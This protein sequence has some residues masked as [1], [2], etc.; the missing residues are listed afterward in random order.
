VNFRGEQT[1]RKTEAE[2]Y[3]GESVSIAIS[4]NEVSISAST[5]VALALTP[6]IKYAAHTK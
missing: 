1:E 6:S 2:Q 5:K 3:K 4:M